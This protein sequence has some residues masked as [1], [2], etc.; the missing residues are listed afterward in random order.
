MM[1]NKK[2]A[3]TMTS[4]SLNLR[5]YDFANNVNPIFYKSMVVILMYFTTIRLVSSMYLV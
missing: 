3:Q 2:L 4:M 5:K 1:S